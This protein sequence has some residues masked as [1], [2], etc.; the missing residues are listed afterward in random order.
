MTNTVFEGKLSVA[1]TAAD[2]RRS[3]KF[4]TDGLGFVEDQRFEDKGAL[5][6]V[7]LSAG[8]AH[9]GLSQDDFSKG[10]DRKKG[11][12]C[13]IYVETDQDVSAL[14]KHAKEA[15]V[16]L[17]R[18]AGPLPWGPMGFT[19]IDPDGFTVTVANRDEG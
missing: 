5:Q 17:S 18:E 9:I 3:L 13:S 1:L 19:A 15:G 6:G 7:M 4:Y 14:A 8:D 2:L 10:R 11:I 16:K 12:G